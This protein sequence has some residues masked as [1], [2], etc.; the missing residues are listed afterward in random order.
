MRLLLAVVILVAATLAGVAVS[1]GV[2]GKAWGIPAALAAGVTL[3][4]AVFTLLGVV[5]VS[6]AKPEFGPLAALAATFG[7][8]VWAAGAVAALGGRAGEFGTTRDA[9][10][11]W[12]A[13]FYV[14]TLFTET[15]LLWWL[16]NRPAGAKP[17][18]TPTKPAE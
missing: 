2:G 15:A 8:M 10:A 4:P 9:L 17:N 3:P 16:L 5:R 12:T 6:A 7:R 13:G 14:L 11:V 18:D 1:A